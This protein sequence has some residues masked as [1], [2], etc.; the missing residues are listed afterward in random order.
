MKLKTKLYGIDS[1]H[2][3]N[4]HSKLVSNR[5]RTSGTSDGLRADFRQSREL[6]TAIQR[7]SSVS[8]ASRAMSPRPVI[9]EDELLTTG[10]DVLP[11]PLQY[12]TAVLQ[13]SPNDTDNACA[14][15]SSPDDTAD[16]LPEKSP[17]DLDLRFKDS[18]V[19]VRLSMDPTILSS[20]TGTDKH[21]ETS[22]SKLDCKPTRKMPLL[23]DQCIL[24]EPQ[25]TSAATDVRETKVEFLY[26]ATGLHAFSPPL[27]P[28]LHRPCAS[29]PSA[30]TLPCFYDQ[31]VSESDSD[32]N[33]QQASSRRAR[34]TSSSLRIVR[35]LSVSST[36]G[37]NLHPDEKSNFSSSWR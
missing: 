13:R 23:D 28:T 22:P 37:E 16:T 11:K 19:K 4:K 26:N 1:V 29:V 20:P 18:L 14:I 15:N 9:H 5:S 36:S 8:P 31:Y 12:D 34:P 35:P 17:E 30:V 10:T 25:S 27:S 24:D 32:E 3:T 2:Q 6:V 33:K 21:K 7:A